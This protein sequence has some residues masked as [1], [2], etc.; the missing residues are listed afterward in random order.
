MDVRLDAISEAVFRLVSGPGR[1]TYGPSIII[2]IGKDV[3]AA[4]AHTD[5]AGLSIWA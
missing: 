2:E 5:F 4:K 1:D 3:R